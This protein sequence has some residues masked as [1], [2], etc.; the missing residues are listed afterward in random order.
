MKHRFRPG[1]SI[2]G[3][4]LLAGLLRPPGAVSAQAEARPDPGIPAQVASAD[5]V[6]S[7]TTSK[8][9]SPRRPTKERVNASATAAAKATVKAK[10]KPVAVKEP[11][12]PSTPPFSFSGVA[13][14][15]SI[16]DDN[17]LRAS[18]STILE[19]R[20][21]VSP[22]KFKIHSYDDMIM[23]PKITLNFGR[24]VLGLRA[25]QLRVS[26]VRF[27]YVRNG[28]KNNSTWMFRLRQPTLG[29]DFLELSYSYSPYSYIRELS[30]RAPT[31]PAS[32]PLVWSA[33]KSTRSGFS[34]GYSR[35]VTDRL[36]VRL[37][38]GRVLRFYN[39]RFMENDNWEWNW[40][41]QAAYSLT[42]A[43]KLSGQYS[44]SNVKARAMDMVGQTIATSPTGDPSY[45]RDLFELTT[46]WN[47]GGRLWMANVIELIG[48][49][50]A[51]YYTS[52]HLYWDDPFHVG[53]KDQVYMIELNATTPPVIGQTTLEAGYRFSQR[54]S[55]ATG[56]V[57][58]GDE[59]DYTDGR[60][61]VGANYPF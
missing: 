8:P 21:G 39:Q 55:S 30:D 59:K 54:T 48:Q 33:F 11:A 56:Q 27:Q 16:Y 35:R 24:R 61:W 13:E 52:K 32:S 58:I 18:A 25:S 51:Y 3:L 23:S 15:Q 41:G 19:F 26:Y 44:Y 10:K 37:D 43:F 31:D 28:P 45:D 6:R 50:Q 9:G 47:T 40:T 1:F 34:L 12:S 4:I 17:I 53:R 5:T 49:Y 29:R 36:N 14:L 42:S 20:Q 46:D 38:G 57:D 22:W 2:P 7:S 60:I